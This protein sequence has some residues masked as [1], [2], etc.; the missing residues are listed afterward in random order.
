MV[1][2]Q[3]ATGAGPVS[4]QPAATAQTVAT[5]PP[6]PAPDFDDWGEETVGDPDRVDQHRLPYGRDQHQ[7][8]QHS[9][10][11]ID[12]P[13]DSANPP[14]AQPPP[15]A[16]SL[17]SARLGT[18]C[19]SSRAGVEHVGE[20]CFLRP[21]DGQRVLGFDLDVTGGVGALERLTGPPS[22]GVAV[23]FRGVDGPAGRLQVDQ[24]G[25]ELEPQLRSPVPGAVAPNRGQ[26]DSMVDRDVLRLSLLF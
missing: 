12:L 1:T 23:A 26:R 22:G 8:V 18:L 4:V 3:S 7:Q 20:C 10:D 2:R 25:G 6:A 13:G 15:A 16:A 11:Q 19:R 17:F 24:V 21:V 5:A 9:T 14:A